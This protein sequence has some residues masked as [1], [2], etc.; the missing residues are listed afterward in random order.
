MIPT[1]DLSD[2]LHRLNA[3]IVDESGERS[4][5]FSGLFLKFFQSNS[6]HK[7]VSVKYWFNDKLGYPRNPYQQSEFIGRN[8]HRNSCHRPSTGENTLHLAFENSVGFKKYEE[9]QF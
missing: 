7:V 5:V 1:T 2:G 4:S 9:H 8:N 3:Y 6:A